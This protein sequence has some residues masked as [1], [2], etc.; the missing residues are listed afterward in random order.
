MENALIDLEQYPIY[1]LSAERGKALVRK[2]REKMKVD[3][4]LL[5]E[6]FIKLNVIK[7]MAEEVNNLQSHRRL[8][9][10]QIFKN[11]PLV[12]KSIYNVPGLPSDHPAFFRMPQDVHA[13]ASDLIP[14]SSLI[15]QVY[16]SKMVMEFIAAVVGQTKI[17]QFNDEFQALNIMYIRDGGSRAWHYDGSDYVVTLLLQASEKGGEFEFAPFIRGEKIGDE[18]YDD[19]KQLFAGKYPTKMTR[20]NA[21]ALAVFNGRRSLHRVRTVYGGRDRIQSVLSYA[22][23]ANERGTPEKNVTLYGERVEKIYE[24][25]GVKLR[26]NGNEKVVLTPSPSSSSLDAK[27]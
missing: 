6:G 8:E 3:G 24:E 26:R 4:S 23:T 16:N 7:K 17:Y 21:G 5:L 11:D 18:C 27:L 19:V 14:K 9:I 12:D 1:D 15:M 22:K 13:V 10:V 2:C 25:R 20:C